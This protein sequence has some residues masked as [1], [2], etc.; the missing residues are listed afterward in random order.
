MR[1]VARARGFTLLELL[2]VL[3]LLS[4]VML[5]MGSALR[6]MAQVEQRMDVR[7][8]RFDEMRVATD[9]LRTVLSRVS[10]RKGAPSDAGPGAHYF[11]G[12]AH[13]VWWLGVM[14]AR[15][16]VGGMHHFRLGL[17]PAGLVL[18]Y[19]AWRGETKPDWGRAESLLLVA[20][21]TQLA[22]R[23]EDARDEPSRW[24]D[25]WAAFDAMPERVA[26]S[27]ATPSGP[28]PVVVVHMR[29]LPGTDPE[30][31]GDPAYGGG[32]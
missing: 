12:S 5:G 21:A 32:R 31:A 14:P 24:V 6:S 20:G 19:Q 18:R 9:F 13:E 3:A 4:L 26:L 8:A 2:V 15:H 27:V 10:A 29:R 25:E 1:A 11:S 7:L 23:F 30:L 17:E 28:W 22:M 16:G